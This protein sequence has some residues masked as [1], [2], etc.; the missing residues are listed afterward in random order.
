MAEYNQHFAS[1][2]SMKVK[3][4]ITAKRFPAICRRFNDK[5]KD[6]SVRSDY[7]E[8]FSLTAWSQLSKEDTEKHTCRNCMQCPTPSP[9]LFNAFPSAKKASTMPTI[10]FTPKDLSSSKQFGR[11]VLRELNVVT[12][13]HF[14][15]PI[16][17]V[18]AETPKSRFV[19]RSTSATRQQEKRRIQNEVKKNIE[20]EMDG[21]ATVLRNRISW[22]KYD[23]MRQVSGLE[24]TRKRTLNVDATDE[25]QPPTKKKR[26]GTWEENLLIDKE[27][28]LAEARLWRPDEK[29]NWSELG[30][31]YGI[32]GANRGQVIKE[33]LADHEI[34]V[35]NQQQRKNRATRRAKKRVKG[36]RLSSD[37][38]TSYHREEEI[39]GKD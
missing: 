38:S 18:L 19:H 26:H 20:K 4:S 39:N 3:Y 34:E 8:A 15:K 30:A 37:A 33:F 10:K 12:N 6:T 9:N 14:S 22:R 23:K 24:T 11:K 21:Q 7:L 5:W 13:T 35:A 36:S 2:A 31:K 25:E 27:E 17:N 28:L 32:E 1:F 16:Q 29:V